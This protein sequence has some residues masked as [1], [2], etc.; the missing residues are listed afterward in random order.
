MK[1][2]KNGYL[3]IGM[4]ILGAFSRLIPHPWNFTAMGA[5]SLLAGREFTKSSYALMVPLAAMLVSDLFLGLHSGIAFTYV[6]MAATVL[7][8][9]FFKDKVSGARLVAWSL[10]SSLLFFFISNFGVWIV[11][12]MYPLNMSGLI[13]CY[14]M[15][16]PFLGGQIAGDLFFTS[17]IFTAYDFLAFKRSFI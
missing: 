11:G 10:M 5:I 7:F 4:I 13:N 9:Y 3:L 2:Q 12:D 1:E 15:G 17:L 16:I 8:A 6:G 14:V